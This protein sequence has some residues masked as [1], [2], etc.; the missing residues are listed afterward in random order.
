MQAMWKENLGLNIEITTYESNTYWDIYDQHQFDIAYDGWT[1]DY[2][3]PSTMLECFTQARQ[4]SQWTDDKALEYDD[5]MNKAAAATDQ[6]ER[7]G[8]FEDAEKLLF[9]EAPMFPLSYK[10]SQILVSDRVEYFTND[11]L[12]HQLLKYTKLK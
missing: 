5:L 9:E 3:D 1:G 10:V 7:F 12:N 8:Y 6:E 4:G 2:D 11:Q